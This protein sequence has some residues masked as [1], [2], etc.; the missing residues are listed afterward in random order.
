MLAPCAVGGL[1]ADLAAGTFVVPDQVVD[2]TWGR[3][4]TIWDAIGPVVH[5]SFADPY[6]PAGRAA[7]LIENE[8]GERFIVDLAGPAV[9]P[10]P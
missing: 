2:R 3:A 5:T 1:R 7:L 4:H 6:C 9:Q 8:R 10:A